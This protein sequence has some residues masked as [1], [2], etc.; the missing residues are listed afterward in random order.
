MI[1]SASFS[2]LAGTGAGATAATSN[3]DFY[4]FS[5][6]KTIQISFKRRL[7]E[8]MQRK[9]KAEMDLKSI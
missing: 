4:H 2:D 9:L 1:T 5:D 8:L 7:C 6:P 3:G